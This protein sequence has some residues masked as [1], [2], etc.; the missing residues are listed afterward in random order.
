MSTLARVCPLGD[1]TITDRPSTMG[2]K[3]QLNA[4]GQSRQG[5]RPSFGLSTSGRAKEGEE[6]AFQAEGTA[7]VEALR[8][9]PRGLEPFTWP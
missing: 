3:G 7:G 4:N 6:R 2:A 8:H 1:V 5:G 9:G